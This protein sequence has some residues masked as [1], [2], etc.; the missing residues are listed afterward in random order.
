M[1]AILGDE[2]DV[3]QMLNTA[4]QLNKPEVSAP[5]ARG[6]AGFARII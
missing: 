3:G 4:L 2:G 5:P 1:E 6:A